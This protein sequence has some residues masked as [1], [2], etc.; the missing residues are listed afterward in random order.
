[1]P[2][3]AERAERAEMRVECAL[4]HRW[5]MRRAQEI[6]CHRDLWQE[7]VLKVL[8]QKGRQPLRSG[9]EVGREKCHRLLASAEQR[10]KRVIGVC[11]TGKGQ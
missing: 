5:E 10:E 8:R 11:I 4:E 9:K 2:E 3:C 1:M 6:G 7:K